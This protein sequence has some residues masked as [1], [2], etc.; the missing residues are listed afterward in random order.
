MPTEVL[1]AYASRYGSTEE[2]ARTIATTLRTCGLAV[3]ATPAADVRDL[4]PY[5]AVVL[6][7]A[8]YMYRWHKAA[9]R[10]LSRHR[11]AL[12]RRAVAVFALG[13]VHEPHDDKEWEDAR[14]QLDRELDRYP[15][16][17][18]VTLAVFGGR[19][20]PAKLRFPINV[21]A[22]SEP[23]SDIRDWD[24]IRSWAEALPAMLEAGRQEPG[25]AQPTRTQPATAPRS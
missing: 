16:L 24:A 9:R 15:W 13:P 10:F 19:F 14:S 2:V 12:D 21:L 3:T 4:E 17:A 25:R 5:D 11:A 7:A 8:L 1:V 18:P 22:G 20:D 23:A 6:G